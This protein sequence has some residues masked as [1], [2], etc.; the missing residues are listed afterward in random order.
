MALF[1]NVCALI[2][3]V[4]FVRFVTGNV[5][6]MGENVS[7]SFD[8]VEAKFAPGIKQ[9]GE[10][11][12]LYLADP[13]DACS[14][15]VNNVARSS[16]ASFA[17]I[18]RGKCSFDDK[19][20]SAQSAGFSAAIIYDSEDSASLIEMGGSPE[21]IKI[22]AVFISKASGEF[23]KKYAGHT[24]T[25]LWIVPTV[26]NSPW[27]IMAVSFVALLAIS[28]MLATCFFVCKHHARRGRPRLP[29]VQEFH[30]MSR[31]LVRAMPSLIFTTVLEDN[32]TSRTC[33]ICLED[34]YMGEKLRILPCCHKFHASCV[35]RW[36]TTW[37]TFCPICKRDARTSI[38]IPPALESTPLLSSGVPSPSSTASLWSCRSSLA[39]SPSIPIAS[40][41]TSP[42]IPINSS[43]P[44][45][46]ATSRTH[47]LASAHRIA[48]SYRSYYNSSSV[49]NDGSSGDLRKFSPQ[50]SPVPHF[51]SPHSGGLPLPSSYSSRYTRP[52]NLSP[53]NA[54]PSYLV[55]SSGLSGQC[56]YLQHCESGAS[57]SALASGHSLPGY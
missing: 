17:L 42:P 5:V 28:S 34:Y 52:Y 33:A 54:S 30:G 36:L 3:H 47:S 13:V 1:R 55:G 20:R 25:E 12:V 57:I 22:H 11:G 21:G 7:M 46:H 18:I 2:V 26:E 41:G 38:N 53:S 39:A 40:M 31:R 45:S 35:D 9:S 19:I 4:M 48:D 15:L 8:D 6:L 24:D 23:L 37:R 43:P 32:C 56:S 14:A 51:M 16:K 10:S 29:Q 49:C 44:W 27:S 50:R